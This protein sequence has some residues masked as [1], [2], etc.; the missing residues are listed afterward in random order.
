[1]TMPVQCVQPAGQQTRP[2]QPSVLRTLQFGD[3]F[4]RQWLDSEEPG[5]QRFCMPSVD[6]GRNG[7][8]IRCLER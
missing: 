7:T 2:W 5:G 4:M 1:M 8:V 6:S 3:A